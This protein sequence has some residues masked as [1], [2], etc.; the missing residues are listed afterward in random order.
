MREARERLGALCDQLSR[1]PKLHRIIRDAGAGNELDALL[2]S[3]GSNDD[4]DQDQMLFWV[5]AIE[6]ACGRKG[7]VGITTRDKVFR[8][9]PDG[10]SA[11]GAPRAW[12]CPRDRCDRVVLPGD[13]QIPLTCAVSGG[14]PLRPFDLPPS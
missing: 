12:V 7:L 14:T 5:E 10:L 8:L 4:L 3:L 2:T 13:T 6:E 11:P 9:L 1:W